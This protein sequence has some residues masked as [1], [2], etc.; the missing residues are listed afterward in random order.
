VNALDFD[1]ATGTLYASVRRDFANY[2]AT[3]DPLTGTITSLGAS[4]SGLDALA[5][6]FVPEPGTLALLAVAALAL[7][8]R[9]QSSAA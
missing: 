7:A 8:R 2:L 1:P 3:L 9:R 5:V 6:F 4:Q